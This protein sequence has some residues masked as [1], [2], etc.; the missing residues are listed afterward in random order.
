MSKAILVPML[1]LMKSPRL[2]EQQAL[3]ASSDWRMTIEG[4]EALTGADLGAGDRKEIANRM[5]VLLAQ[6]LK[7]EFVPEERTERCRAAIHMQRMRI[8]IVVMKRPGLSRYPGR[9]LAEGYRAARDRA[10]TETGLG[11]TSF[12][13]DCP[14]SAV[15]SLDSDYLPA[16]A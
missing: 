5:T 3:L 16:A 15:E 4:V 13:E 9:I 6:L 14:Y 2:W 1:L 8:A 12:P 10:M 7:W 11:E